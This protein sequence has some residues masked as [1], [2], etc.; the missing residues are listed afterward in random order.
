MVL[1]ENIYIF[2]NSFTSTK[3]LL[4]TKDILKGKEKIIRK[5]KDYHLPILI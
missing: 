2:A 5:E 4:H 1:E 3:I